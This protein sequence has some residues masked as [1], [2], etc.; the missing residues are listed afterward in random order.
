MM[1]NTQTQ[2]CGDVSVCVC[3]C[4][5]VRG[6]VCV[7]VCV[8]PFC[9]GYVPCSYACPLWDSESR[10]GED[11]LFHSAGV[12]V[13]VCYFFVCLFVQVPLIYLLG[14]ERERGNSKNKTE[15]CSGFQGPSS[16]SRTC[17][18]G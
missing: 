4:V 5:C 12:C 11:R 1:E 15:P 2:G 9:S 14:R 16:I 3:V 8:V 13:C 18:L 7:Y 17:F 10:Q 6:R